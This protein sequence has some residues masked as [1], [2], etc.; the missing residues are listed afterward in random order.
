MLHALTLAQ[1]DE[2]SIAVGAVAGLFTSLLWVFTSLFFTAAGKRLGSTNVNTSRLFM[3]LLIHGLFFFITTGALFPSANTQQITDLALSGVI[4]LAIGD[5]FLFTAFLYTGPRLAIL[6]MTTAPVWATLLGYTFLDEVLTPV[7]LAG[8][9]TTIAAVIWA[10]LERPKSKVDA[11]PHPHFRRGI[12]FAVIG[13]FCQAAGL[14][15]SKT[16]MGVDILPPDQRLGPQAATYIRMLFACAAIIPIFLILNGFH[17][18]SLAK[19]VIPDRIG[20]KSA[21]YTLAL[22]GAI[23][24]PVLGVWLSLIAAENAPVGVAQT[25]CGLSPVFILPFMPLV[26]KE[27]VSPRAILAALLAVGG[28][29]IIV[30]EE[31]IRAALL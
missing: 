19:G 13:A 1:A 24:G 12:V 14:M 11:Q 2:P 21:G 29:A 15:W 30:F 26:M 27:H 23:C 25:L 9:A 16:G 18:K 10:V 28:V 20:K 4:G 3:A 17:R 31:P 5:Q 22:F 7:T 6:C 8:M